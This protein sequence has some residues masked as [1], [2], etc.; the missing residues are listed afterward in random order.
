MPDVT[1][2]RLSEFFR[3]K[4]IAM[5][6]ATDSFRMSGAAYHNL[7]LHGF[8]GQVHLVNP[9][10]PVVTPANRPEPGEIDGPVRSGLLRARRG[11]GRGTGRTSRRARHPEPR[12]LAGGFRETGAEGADRERRLLEVADK[13]GQVVLGPTPSAS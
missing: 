11:A 5:V 13:Y 8:A 4:N 1:S 10:T 9:R 7:G 2:E 6:G 3:P 12:C